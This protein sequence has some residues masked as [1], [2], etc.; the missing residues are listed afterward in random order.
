LDLWRAEYLSLF[1]VIFHMPNLTT[2]RIAAREIFSEVLDAVDPRD[3]LHRAVCVDRS[4]LEICGETFDLTNRKVY[5]IAIGKAAFAMAS[6]LQAILNERLAGGVATTGVPR[7]NA[8]CSRSR[9]SA[10]A[11]IWQTFEGG[12]PE[13]NE[14]S[15][16]GARACF[17]LLERADREGALLIFLISGGGSAMIEW[18]L[19]ED[20]SL[21]D[22]RTA[23]RALVSC[24]ASI[25]EIN[26]V[27]RAFSAVKGGRLGARALHCEQ[28]TLIVSDVPPGAEANVASGPTLTPQSDSPSAAEV[29]A[30]YSL[31]SSLPEAILRSIDSEPKVPLL[32]EST[33]LRK[34]FVLLDNLS[35]LEAAAQAGRER[36]F[37]VE[38][39]SDI[40]D[41]PIDEGSTALLKCLNELIDRSRAGSTSKE[42]AACL[43]SG[44]EF[45]C[46]VRG[47]GIGGRN[48]E[49]ALRLAM[50][51][52][53]NRSTMPANFVALCAGTD[54]IDGNSPA[55]GA[56]V[57]SSTI[58]RAPAIGFDPNDFLA[59]SNAYSF[60]VALGDVVATGP[61]GTNVRDLRILL[62]SSG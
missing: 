27:R 54:G 57:D 32:N 20:I 7:P 38:I 44:G 46:P 3:A 13:P 40:C 6:G 56:I 36:G 4:W 25:S 50:D 55:A 59:R 60:F 62:A 10:L 29:V 15:L 52:D 11:G 17:E 14:Q 26:A 30:H 23:N 12:H 18:P 45:A 19:N 2:L 61:T 51:C 53:R 21:A 33:S 48:L 9:M 37:A 41:Q 28:V 34:H 8:G 43:I 35:A 39:A 24:G 31:Y 49:T 42:S 58:G 1:A 47:D 5:S 22:L 16:A